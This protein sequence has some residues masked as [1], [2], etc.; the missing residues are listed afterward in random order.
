MWG[1]RSSWRRSPASLGGGG[2]STARACQE[3]PYRRDHLLGAVFELFV[4]ETDGVPAGEAEQPI[5]AAVARERAGSLEVGA[6]AV[7][8]HDQARRPPD[9]VHIDLLTRNGDVHVQLRPGDV[10][11]VHEGEEQLLEL[12]AG[13]R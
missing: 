3:V 6:A 4:C 9:A 10:G 7:Q 11:L 1:S 2:G 12:A 13:E 8:L 5:A